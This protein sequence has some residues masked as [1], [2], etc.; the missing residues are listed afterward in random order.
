MSPIDFGVKGQGQGGI[1]VVQH[2]LLII[3]STL[4]FSKFIFLYCIQK[5]SVDLVLNLLD[6]SDYNG[7]KISVTRAQFTLK[8]DYDPSKKKKKL[9]NKEKRRLKERQAKYVEIIILFA[10]LSLNPPLFLYNTLYGDI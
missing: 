10:H 5:E 7:H 8:G 3:M 9:T 4:F 1:C 6:G 2:F